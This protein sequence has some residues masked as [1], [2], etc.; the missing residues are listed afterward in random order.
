MVAGLLRV[1]DPILMILPVPR[2]LLLH[3]WHDMLRWERTGDV[4]TYAV[5]ICTYIR[6]L[7]PSR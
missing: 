4:R 5:Y 6:Y 7:V 2:S 3:R 1:I